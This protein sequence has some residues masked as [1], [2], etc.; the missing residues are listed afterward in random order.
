VTR[1]IAFCFLALAAV[2]ARAA[3]VDQTTSGWCSPA[4]AA[5][6]GKVTIVCNG[7]DPKALHRLNELLDKKDV[8]LAKKIAEAE[9]WARRY[10]ELE[11]RLAD[12]T[13]NAGRADD[14]KLVADAQRSLK[15]GDLEKAGALLDRL[16]ESS[17]AEVERAAT[18][19]YSRAQL[20]DL[21]FKAA[22]ALSHYERAHRYRPEDLK[23]SLAY[24][25]AL[26]NADRYAEAEALYVDNVRKLRTLSRDD[27]KKY[28]T[29]LAGNLGNLA[30]LRSDTG[31]L[32][33][34]EEASRE[35]LEILRRLAGDESLFHLPLLAKGLTLQGD[36]YRRIF[37][38]KEAEEVYQEAL[39]LRRKLAATDASRYLPEVAGTLN[40]LGHLYLTT[41]RVAGAEKMFAEAL[42][43]FQ[44]LAKE[45]PRPICP[46]WS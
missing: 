38:W 43:T 8:E 26:F 39:N 40:A 12:E 45:K 46:T 10:R 3:T 9:E 41:Q 1:F 6:Q 34:A 30:Y 24:A 19:H 5:V 18:H 36:V 13:N 20:F 4:V 11:Q 37:R 17:E 27:P 7:V 32:K 16:I 44:G 33:E 29:L 25:N 23:Y 28:L 31:R 42:V 35:S 14:A 2:A 22:Q 15:E 21:Q